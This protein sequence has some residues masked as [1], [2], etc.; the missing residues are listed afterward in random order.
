M[1]VLQTVI[2]VINN[3]RNTISKHVIKVADSS[4]ISNATSSKKKMST[5]ISL[6]TLSFMGFLFL[7][8]QGSRSVNRPLLKHIA[9][10]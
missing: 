6:R 7:F 3:E 9:E 2:V 1:Q 4:N 10:I 5:F 8:L